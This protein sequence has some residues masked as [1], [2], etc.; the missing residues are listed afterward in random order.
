MPYQILFGPWWGPLWLS[1]GIHC[2]QYGGLAPVAA[3]AALREERPVA[4]HTSPRPW[5]HPVDFLD[6]V[7]CGTK[8]CLPQLEE[9]RL[10]VRPGDLG[11]RHRVLVVRRSIRHDLHV[12]LA[13]PQSTGP[14]H[15]RKTLPRWT[16]LW[17]EPH[18]M[19]RHTAVSMQFLPG[20]SNLIVG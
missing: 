10:V 14:L 18:Y 9:W 12:L 2:G 3:P 1:A 6:T 5:P 11:R 15:H 13:R 19:L 17:G 16:R 4:L 8:S 20:L 7:L